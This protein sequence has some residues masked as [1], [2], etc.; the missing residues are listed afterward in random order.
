MLDHE[1]QPKAPGFIT[2]DVTDLVVTWEPGWLPTTI[3]RR[4]SHFKVTASFEGDGAIW[5]WVECPPHG[6]PTDYEARFYAEGIGGA[7]KEIDFPPVKGTLVCQQHKYKVELDVPNGIDTD[8]IY[9][10]GVTL[11]FPDYPGL[12]GF[13]EGLHFQVSANA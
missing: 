8:G 9:S 3:V 12:T 4:N 11:T 2:F 6:H 10:F 1:G 7:P 5:H 13:C